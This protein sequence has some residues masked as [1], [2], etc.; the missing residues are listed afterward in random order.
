MTTLVVADR[1]TGVADMG[2]NL[3]AIQHAVMIF[4]RLAV[5]VGCNGGSNGCTDSGTDDRALAT[6]N[7]GADRTTQCSTNTATNRRVERLIIAGSSRESEQQPYREE[8]TLDL[9]YRT[10]GTRDNGR[11]S[12]MFPRNTGSQSQSDREVIREVDREAR[13]APGGGAC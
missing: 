12:Q 2:V 13:H 10:S 4:G 1:M 9:Q 11:V 3:D 6:T 7:F 5:I 8:Q